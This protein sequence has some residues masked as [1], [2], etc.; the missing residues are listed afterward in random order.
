MWNDVHPVRHTGSEHGRH[1]CATLLG[2]RFAASF[3]SVG[4]SIGPGAGIVIPVCI[5]T[6]TKC[7]ELG[8]PTHM[9]YL[10]TPQKTIV[11]GRAAARTCNCSCR[12]WAAMSDSSMEHVASENTALRA[13]A[14]ITAVASRSAS[15]PA[16]GGRTTLVRSSLAAEPML[17]LAVF[18]V[19]LAGAS[20]SLFLESGCCS[21][22]GSAP[23]PLFF[24]L[25]LGFRSFFLRLSIEAHGERFP[26]LLRALDFPLPL[27]ETGRAEPPLPRVS[28]GKTVPAWELMLKRLTRRVPTQGKRKKIS[29]RP[30]AAV[31]VQ[32]ESERECRETDRQRERDR[33][34]DRERQR[35]REIERDRERERKRQR[36]TKRDRERQR[37]IEGDRD[38]DRDRGR[39]TERDRET[40]R[41]RERDS[42][43]ASVSE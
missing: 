8:A 7:N 24:F 33:E 20:L 9:E 4:Y 23:R 14:P 25:T 2:R 19:E 3:W 28:F 27:G 15:A 40:E 18:A 39:Q 22:S 12:F 10:V 5:R 36:E 6:N 42:E 32:R 30:S 38:R 37:E 11:A 29:C 35:D 17:S 26:F 1:S 21:G 13:V 16:A 41:Q 31:R 34:R 43:R